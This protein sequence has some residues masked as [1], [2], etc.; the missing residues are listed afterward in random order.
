MISFFKIKLIRIA[1]ILHLRIFGHEMSEE[2]RKFLGHLSWSF[3]GGTIAA[4][5]MFAS[6]IL[7]GRI[8]GP[9]EYGKYSFIVAFSAVAVLFMTLGI[10]VTTLHYVAKKNNNERN[11]YFSTSFFI[12]L[13]LATIC[14]F[15][16]FLFAEII[17]KK[18]NVVEDVYFFAILFTFILALKNLFD[19]YLRGMNLFEKQAIAKVAEAI[20]VGIFFIF[21]YF[22]LSKDIDYRAYVGSLIAGAVFLVMLIF[23][24]TK[25]YLRLKSFSLAALKEVF[26]YGLFVF[27]GGIAATLLFSFDKILINKFLGGVQ[28]GI[29]NA[30]F[31]S[32]MAIVTQ[33]TA[34][35]LNV[36][37]PMAS[38]IKDKKEIFKKINR[39]SLFLLIPTFLISCVIIRIS[40]LLFGQQYPTDWVLIWKF[41]MLSLLYAYFT[42]LW[43]FISSYGVKGI[44][45]TSVISLMV[46]IIFISLVIFF[47]NIVSL[48]MIINFLFFVIL[49]AVTLGTFSIKKGY[50]NVSNN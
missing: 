6:N 15:V 46:G 14:F 23:I 35:F 48:D 4:G 34:I 43:W 28:L 3:F 26:F 31:I 1:E 45:F 38:S 8:L 2:M 5:I 27:L 17:S 33:F 19:S 41:S 40:L 13:I 11:K 50:F 24:S 30:Y 39:L 32:S 9:E 42:I 47:R 36:F 44:R 37:F 49:G 22:L 25:N 20:T 29:Y 7:A 18:L 12:V 10:D 16:L 21:S